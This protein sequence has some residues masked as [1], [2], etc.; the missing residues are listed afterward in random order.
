MQ[1]AETERGLLN[2]PPPSRWMFGT[3]YPSQNCHRMKAIISK[4]MVFESYRFFFS[5]SIFDLNG[6]YEGKK[7]ALM[8]SSFLGILVNMQIGREPKTNHTHIHTQKVSLEEWMQWLYFEAPHGAGSS[9]SL[10]FWGDSVQRTLM[11]LQPAV[12]FNQAHKRTHKYKMNCSPRIWVL[13]LL[14]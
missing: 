12:Y 7:R 8:V 1:A 5:S 14:G 10:Q 2:G 4:L 13:K 3:S 6:L 11:Q 9:Y